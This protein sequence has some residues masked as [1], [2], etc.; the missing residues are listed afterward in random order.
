MSKI[1]GEFF[2]EFCQP[3]AP[4]KLVRK[5]FCFLQKIVDIKFPEFTR[6]SSEFKFFLM[7]LSPELARPI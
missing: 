3:A 4:K 6:N 7:G 5:K 2:S 1:L